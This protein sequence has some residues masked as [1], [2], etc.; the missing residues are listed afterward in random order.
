[1][2][3]LLGLIG[4]RAAALDEYEIVETEYR[5]AGDAPA[6]ARVLR[7]MGGPHWDAGARARALQ[8]FEAGITLLGDLASTSSRRTSTPSASP[9]LPRSTQMGAGKR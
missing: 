8:C 5:A 1:M 4:R 2:A 7:K 9:P 6:Q 3:D